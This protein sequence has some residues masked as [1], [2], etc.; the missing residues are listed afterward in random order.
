MSATVFI[1][2]CV[3]EPRPYTRVEPLAIAEEGAWRVYDQWKDVLPDEGRVFSP[4]SPGFAVGELFGFSVETNERVDANRPDRF[5]LSTFSK[6]EQVLDFRSITS[7]RARQVIVEHGLESLS[8]GSDRVV[9]ALQDGTCS[10]VTMVRHPVTNRWVA[11]LAGLEGLAV[12]AFNAAVFDG[13]DLDGRRFAVPGVTVGERI[14]SLDWRPDS[15]FLETVLKR[16]RKIAS[17]ADPF[18]L[19]RA[20]LSS[21]LAYLSRA[22]LMPSAAED[23]S[24]MKDRLTTVTED[25]TA[26]AQTLDKLVDLLCDLK[27]VKDS[28]SG[29]IERRRNQLEAEIRAELELK[30]RAALDLELQ[31][32]TEAH[33][34]LNAEAAQT[35]VLV[36][37]RRQATA[38]LEV[39]Y[40]GLINILRDQLVGFRGTLEGLP[41]ERQDQVD[42]I[43]RRIGEQLRSVAP[44]V[45]LTPGQS[46]PWTRIPSIKVALEP[47]DRGARNLR[48]AGKQWGYAFE[49]LACADMAARAG[50]LVLLRSDLASEFCRC[51]A[52][53]LAGG[54]VARQVLDPAVL[55]LNDLWRLPPSSAPTAFS[56]AWAAATTEPRRYQILLLDGLER[57]PLD[58]WLP[59]LL[60]EL[61]SARRPDN[62]LVFGAF[63]DRI[64]DRDRVPSDLSGLVVPVVPV[65]LAGISGEAL[66]RASG[67][68]SP[69]SALDA[70]TA[71]HPKR[72]DLLEVLEDLPQAPNQSQLTLVLRLIAS[73][74][75]LRSDIDPKVAA[76]ILVGSSSMR[77]EA[78]AELAAFWR[79]RDWLHDL[80][81]GETRS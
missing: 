43:F 38:D 45:E 3:F 64:L 42:A 69:A 35:Q 12:H 56:L 75:A 22:E 74:W 14:G 1:G 73:A 10:V 80:S 17:G 60:D 78:T 29:E 79:G 16:L 57:T 11:T 63:G 72:S 61:R 32:A 71:P 37:E 30:V 26:N 31:T 50:A 76:Q 46:A 41:A 48:N 52:S 62:L 53:A 24:R 19:H 23:L 44:G 66:S 40:D 21:L 6:L 58:L 68:A 5:V 51:Y 70:T 67:A 4:R 59:S 8:R 65:P 7:E 28:L 54:N 27:S 18:P 34:R 33:D 81:L 49:D 36:E 13:D 47:W 9:V 20:Q 39:A 15:E 25:L 55:S 77:Q 2:S